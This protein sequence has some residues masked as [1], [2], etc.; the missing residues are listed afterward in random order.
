MVIFL[1]GGTGF[2]GKRFIKLAIKNDHS[3]YAITR[4]KKNSNVVNLK[5]LEGDINHDW[6]KYIKKSD[7]IVHLA[8]EGIKKNSSKNK[9]H[10]IDFNVNKTIS[11]FLNA[12]KIGCKK[13]IIASSSSEYSHNG[14]C[15]NNLTINSKRN[16]S[17][18]YSFSKIIVTDIMR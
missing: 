1:T 11:F 12:I 6:S 14:L 15:K 18:V 3:I 13:F 17:S 16:F 9:F 4:K 2:I 10:V 5:W 8:A 7:V